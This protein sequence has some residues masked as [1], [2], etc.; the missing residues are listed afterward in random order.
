MMRWSLI[1]FSFCSSAQRH[2]PQAVSGS[3]EISH[4][5]RSNN[6]QDP[7]WQPWQAAGQPETTVSYVSLFAKN[8]QRRGRHGTTSFFSKNE[9]RKF[10]YFLPDTPWISPKYYTDSSDH[11]QTTFLCVCLS[12]KAYESLLSANRVMVLFAK[13]FIS[14]SALWFMDICT[15]PPCINTIP[16]SM[17]DYFVKCIWGFATVTFTGKPRLTKQS[18]GIYG[19]AAC[20]V[21]PRAGVY[22]I[23]ESRN[24]QALLNSL[25]YVKAAVDSWSLNS[26]RCIGMP[27][28]IWNQCQQIS[29]SASLAVS[30]KLTK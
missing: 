15:P 1:S 2:K 23:W 21:R 5:W 16:S 18:G 26:S 17:Q 3:L 4:I 30:K 7:S 6:S 19:S 11:F 29:I 8:Q 24:K 25:L 22:D 12:C 13:I 27:H 9:L 20:T 14:E 10:F 28:F